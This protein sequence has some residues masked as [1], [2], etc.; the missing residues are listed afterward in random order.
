MK[1]IGSTDYRAR[2]FGMLVIM[3]PGAPLAL[4]LPHSSLIPKGINNKNKKKR[5]L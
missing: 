2:N 4:Q 3:L 5:M 1:S